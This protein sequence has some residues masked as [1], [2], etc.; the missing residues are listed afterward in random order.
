M[1]RGKHPSTGSIQSLLVFL[2]NYRDLFEKDSN[3]IQLLSN[4]VLEIE[5]QLPESKQGLVVPK[6]GHSREST[7]QIPRTSYPKA[8]LSF[9]TRSKQ[10]R[11]RS[12]YQVCSNPS[13]SSQTGSGKIKWREEVAK[14]MLELLPMSVLAPF[15]VRYQHLVGGTQFSASTIKQAR[16]AVMFESIRELL[17]DYAPPD[18]GP[19]LLQELQGQIRFTSK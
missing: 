5:E 6:I 9:P 2:D 13:A 17:V 11:S 15:Y 19:K 18:Q 3:A 7:V 8:P 10:R 14:A 4:I 16:K 1:Q 12:L